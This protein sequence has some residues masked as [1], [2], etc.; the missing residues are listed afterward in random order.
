MVE[1]KCNNCGAKIPD[2]AQFCPGCGATK[3]TG[4]TAPKPVQAQP[5]TPAM[6]MTQRGL[7]PLE[8]VF[9]LI[10]SKTVV[11]I[12]IG[13]GILLAWIG[14]LI[15]IFSSSNAD[16]ATFLNT[17]GFA[18]MGLILIGAGIWNKKIDKYVRLG[19]LVIGGA[20]I[21][22]AVSVSAIQMGSLSSFY[23]QFGNIPGFN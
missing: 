10:F 11:I 12:G 13:I 1:T 9:D 20:A 16:I 21:I 8:G 19:M 6:S 7:S 15:G 17:S 3:G 4:Q 23:N 2:G 18:G 14:V 22:W 5:V